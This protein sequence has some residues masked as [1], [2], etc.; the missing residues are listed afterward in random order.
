MIPAKQIDDE[1]IATSHILHEINYQNSYPDKC[2]CLLEYHM[3][4]I[5]QS[6]MNKGPIK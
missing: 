5:T 3:S 1:I 4:I 6:L 2:S